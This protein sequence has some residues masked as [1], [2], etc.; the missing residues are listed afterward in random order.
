MKDEPTL[1]AQALEGNEI[2]R[3]L[4]TDQASSWV[5]PLPLGE[6]VI[7]RGI[8]C[9]VR[10][11]DSTV[12][13]THATIRVDPQRMVSVKDLGSANGSSLN[14]K[15]LKGEAPIKPGDVLRVGQATIYLHLGNPADGQRLA[16]A[17]ELK[18]R[19]VAEIERSVRNDC[20]C[21]LLEVRL[22]STSSTALQ[23]VVSLLRP[24]DTVTEVGPT[25]VLVLLPELR[26]ELVKQQAQAVIDGLSAAGIRARVGTATAPLD[27]ADAE[28]LFNVARA[29]AESAPPGGVSLP[30]EI[31]RIDLGEEQVLVGDPDMARA[32]AMLERLAP[33]DIS[34]LITGETGASWSTRSRRGAQVPS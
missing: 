31:R 19:V 13:R 4:V 3:L 6:L 17:A 1:R 28:S 14:G 25:R 2:L 32:Y 20:P 33:T 18:R 12:S 21:A 9:H 5:V 24:S 34:V 30:S 16:T 23:T 27:A 29:A 10:L 22:E 7:G 11:E 15:P 26:P 8:E